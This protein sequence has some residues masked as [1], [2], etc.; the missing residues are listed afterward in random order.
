MVA[1]ALLPPL[2]TFGMLLGAGKLSLARGA[3]LLTAANVICVNLAGVAT[4]VAQGV[5]PRTWWEADRAR[6]ATRNA[7]LVWLL[8]LLGLAAILLWPRPSP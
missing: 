7:T 2:V 1:V 6:R 8:L 3:L 5:R 4:F